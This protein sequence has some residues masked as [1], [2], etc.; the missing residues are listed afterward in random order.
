MKTWIFIY[1]WLTRAMTKCR[2]KAA[3]AIPRRAES[4]Q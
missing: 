1:G 3:T 2:N 4:E